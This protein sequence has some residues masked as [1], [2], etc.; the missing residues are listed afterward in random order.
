MLSETA[1]LFLA[2]SGAVLSAPLAGRQANITV[3]DDGAVVGFPQKV[4]SDAIGNAYL[5]F[6]PWL[7]VENGCVPFPAAEANGD[8]RY[9]YASHPPAG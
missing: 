6:K 1:T 5:T 7:Y 8:V 4:P 9:I 3:I 2:A